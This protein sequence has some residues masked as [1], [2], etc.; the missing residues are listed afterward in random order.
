VEHLALARVHQGK[1]PA[2]EVQMLDGP[3][4]TVMTI[5]GGMILHVREYLDTSIA[6]EEIDFINA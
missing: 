3:A 6:Q 1:G 5:F 2:D 4:I